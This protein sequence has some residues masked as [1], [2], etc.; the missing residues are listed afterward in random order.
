MPQLLKKVVECTK[1]AETK[2]AHF[3]NDAEKTDATEV[4]IRDLM[5]KME[6]MKK[7]K[8]ETTAAAAPATVAESVTFITHSGQKSTKPV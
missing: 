8:K 6:E 1:E 4:A 2:A 5:E 3:E 7:V